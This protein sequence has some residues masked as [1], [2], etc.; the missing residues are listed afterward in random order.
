MDEVRAYCDERGNTV[1]PE[2][3]VAF[4]A[5]KGWKIGSTPM[6]DWKAAVVTWEKREAA[7]PA[8]QRGGYRQPEERESVYEHNMKVMDQLMGTHTYED[9][10]KRMNERLHKR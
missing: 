9:F 2:A 6:K 8:Q 3:F 1:D 10:K 5:S 7:R 4:Y